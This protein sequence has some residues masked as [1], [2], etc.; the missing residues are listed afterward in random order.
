MIRLLSS[1]KVPAYFQAQKKNH[2]LPNDSESPAA[3]YLISSVSY[4]PNTR[5]DTACGKS[6][7]AKSNLQQLSK[8]AP[9]ENLLR[10]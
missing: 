5:T 10:K 1:L 4:G 2:P 3:V 8:P 6:A 7:Y 9:T